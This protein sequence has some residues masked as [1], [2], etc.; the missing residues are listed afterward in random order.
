MIKYLKWCYICNFIY[1][2]LNLNQCF[3]AAAFFI[4]LEGVNVNI[5]MVY[6]FTYIYKKPRPKKY[7][8]V[9]GYIL[10]YSY[11]FFQCYNIFDFI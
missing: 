2:M 8:Y 3:K 9:T 5:S 4:P 1:S 11:R 7:K 10:F 6:F